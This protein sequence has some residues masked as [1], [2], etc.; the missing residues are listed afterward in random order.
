MEKMIFDCEVITP[1]FL[2]G[3]DG[4]TPELRAPSIKGAM[5]F[6]WRAVQ[7]ENNI[8]EMKKAE[9][10]IFGDSGEGGR[11]KF[12]IV[13]TGGLKA[14]EKQKMLPHHT[15]DRTC[16]YLPG[17]GRKNNPDCCSKGNMSL[18]LKQQNFQVILRFN[19]FPVGFSREKL[20]ALFKLSSCL[21]GLGRRSRRG[22]GS[23]SIISE[24]E[25]KCDSLEY[26]LG[27]LN[28]VAS[29][30]FTIKEKSIILNKA[31][32][33]DYPF[34]HKIEVGRVYSTPDELLKTIGRASHEAAA[35]CQDKSLGSA[36][37]VRLAS[38]VYVSVL[39][40]SSGYRP[41][42]TTLQMV[43]TNGIGEVNTN[44]QEFFKEAIL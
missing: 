2:Y 18:A 22:F 17:C 14:T 28:I 27:L 13:I 42:I 23:F 36:I 32:T 31:C 20:E 6:W 26:L 37:G 12:S 9:D 44:K 19:E 3:A 40:S 10:S 33:A 4:K 34:I 25:K 24:R 16:P 15:G 29:G 1:M 21:G 39:K 35:I 7:A 5:R 11:S 43:L 30:N 38:P 8:E 41:V